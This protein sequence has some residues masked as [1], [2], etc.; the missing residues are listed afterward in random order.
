MKILLGISGSSS[1]HLGLKL[2]K[3]LENKCELYCII[4]EGAK[5][6]FEAENKKN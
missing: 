5:I 6:S 3:N 2:L 4:T 1:T